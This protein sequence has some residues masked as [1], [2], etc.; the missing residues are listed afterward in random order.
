MLKTSFDINGILYGILSKSALKSKISGGIYI[1]DDR[2]QDSE[3]EDVEINTISITQEYLPQIATSNINIYVPDQSVKI[4]G[5]QQLKSSRTR[6]KE[7]T[8]IALK[9]VRESSIDNLVAIPMSQTVL[10]EPGVNQHSVN[11][12]IKWNIQG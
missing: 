2:P 10:K 11:I 4:G 8:D 6:L 5:V 3:K 12:R 9:A 1:G 7:L